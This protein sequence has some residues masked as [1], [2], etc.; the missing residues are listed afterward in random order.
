MAVDGAL[1]GDG[2]RELVEWISTEGG[3]RPQV[4]S[5]VVLTRAGG[6]DVDQLADVLGVPAQTLRRR[7]LRAE[8][9]LTRTIE[10]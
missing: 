3:L 9:H 7:R 8:Q 2:L 1:D 10:R 6:V 4:A 5:E